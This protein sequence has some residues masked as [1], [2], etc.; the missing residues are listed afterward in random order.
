MAKATKKAK[1]TEKF[2]GLQETKLLWKKTEPQQWYALLRKLAPDSKWQLSGRTIKGCCPYHQDKTPSFILNF[3]KCLGK[4]FG[5]CGKTVTDLVQL[6]AK[7]TNDSYAGALTFLNT[8]FDLTEI[9]GKSANELTAYHA[10]QEM[11]KQALVAM[12]SVA[13]EYLRDKPRHLEYMQPA[14][15]Y[16][17]RGRGIPLGLI[18]RL[19]VVIY[20]KPEHVKK[21]MAETYH[22][23]Y[24]DYMKT[25]DSA[26]WYGS[27]LFAYNDAPGSISRFK[28]RLM[29]PTASETLSKYSSDDPIPEQLA[30]DLLCTK[31]FTFLNDPYSESL[32]IF[33]LHH[34]SRMV[35]NSDTNAY[36]TEGEF[37]AL[38]VM[39]AQIQEDRR[40]FVIFAAGGKSGTDLAF[41]REYGVRCLWV[42][43]DSPSKR[44]DEFAKSLMRAKGNFVGDTINKALSYKIFQWPATVHGGDLD[45]AVKLT[46][47]DTMCRYLCAERNTYFLNSYKWA[48]KMCSDEIAAIKNGY[49]NKKLLTEATSEAEANVIIA[50]LEDDQRRDVRGAIV[51]WLGCVHD[52]IDKL[53]YTRHFSEKEG[54][55]VTELSEVSTNVYALDTMEGAKARLFAD[56]KKNIELAY[57]E[58]K[59]GGNQFTLWSKTQCV[60]AAIPMTERGLEQ[61][62]SQYIGKDVLSWAKGLLGNSPVLLPKSSGDEIVDN[63]RMLKNVLFLIQRIFMDEIGNTRHIGSLSTIGQG[64]HYKYVPQAEAGNYCYFV[65]GTKAFRGKFGNSSGM[66]IEWEFLNSVV[67]GDLLF[68]LHPSKKWSVIDDVSDLY[69]GTSVDLK[70]TFEK[71]LK[72]LDGWKFEH[73]SLMREYLAAWIMSIPIQK[74][75]GQVNITFFTG[76]STSGKTSFVK[77]LLG[78]YEN[79]GHG[80]PPIL[81]AAR[82]AT[83]ATPAWIYQEM[84]GTSLLLGLD[85]AESGQ[86]TDH[87]DRVHEIQNMMYSIP[88]GGATT[89]RGGISADQRVSYFLRMP[90]IMSGINMNS[91]PVFLTRVMVVYTKKDPTRRDVGDY[92]ADN[93]SEREIV[94][95]RKDITTGLLSR[96]PEIIERKDRLYQTLLTTPTATTVTSRFIISVLT[97]LTV[98]EMI[99]GNPV[100]MFQE[101][102]EKNRGRLE[103]LHGHDFQSD[104]LNAVLYTESVA[105]SVEEG[106]TGKVSPR[107][108]IMESDFVL[109]N[110]SSCGVYFIP[111]KGWIVIVWRLAKYVILDRHGFRGVDEASMVEA[112]SKNSYVITDIS[113]AD[114]EYIRSFLGIT[115]IKS[116]SGYTVVDSKYLMDEETQDLIMRRAESSSSKRRQ[117]QNGGA[118]GGPTVPI[119]AYE[120]EMFA[121]DFGDFTL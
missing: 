9:Y 57:Y 30:R 54:I 16:L 66:P 19:P 22:K 93:F 43:Q 21:Y 84:N 62:L 73:H 116:S 100:R 8:E 64:I 12:R 95:L 85:E 92:M 14:L 56:M 75:V 41:L 51:N 55:D 78:G 27:L 115:D 88:T 38:A 35:C 101:I 18:D 31:E 112:V 40:D 48:V 117:E 87:G 20:P 80:V 81:E 11:K 4:C 118:N 15:T 46:G 36:I 104:L 13:S 68:L 2:L 45:D 6:I 39:V 26:R 113:L 28:L 98:Y 42:V 119:E 105:A 109:L 71:I 70:A 5:S 7:I 99:G 67:D 94:Q 69:E 121:D 83:D 44:G 89:M 114:H 58:M 120:N 61:V 34:Y 29:S 23:L 53:E 91:D 65:N 33:G 74:A 3:D 77:G 110:N 86:D 82:C 103:A 79:A 1:S 37:D 24:M 107:K 47:Y 17:T 106:V 76:E 49:Q 25:V 72:V 59:G 102:I 52:Q 32:G 50:N 90:V 96:I 10:C 111:A 97:V 108:L 60:T 63:T